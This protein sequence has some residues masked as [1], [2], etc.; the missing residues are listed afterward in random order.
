ME[1][2]QIMKRKDFLEFLAVARAGLVGRVGLV[3]VREREVGVPTPG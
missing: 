1:R 3:V 2:W